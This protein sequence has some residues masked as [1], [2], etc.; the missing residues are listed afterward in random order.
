[1]SGI[2]AF[3]KTFNLEQQGMFALGYYHQRARDRAQM[4]EA[5][6]RRRNAQEQG[7]DDGSETEGGND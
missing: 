3:P 6:D 4:R 5:S 7:G 2:N 1:M